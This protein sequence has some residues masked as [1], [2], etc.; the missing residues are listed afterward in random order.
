MSDDVP[1]PK[2][3]W[4]PGPWQDEPDESAW[5]E[6][7]L[8]CRLLRA[9]SGAWCGYV[10]VHV[11]HPW[12]GKSLAELRELVEVHGDISYAADRNPDDIVASDR[13][14]IGFDCGH[15]G[16]KDEGDFMPAIL[17]GR[18]E[19]GGAA[20]VYKTIDFAKEQCLA[21]AAQIARAE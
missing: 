18:I 21:L 19:Q 3:E 8:R 17:G 2:D 13:W 1:R 4:G 12:Y 10:G 16:P 9:L 7:Q 11:G 6:G 20:G 15:G 5:L 14:W